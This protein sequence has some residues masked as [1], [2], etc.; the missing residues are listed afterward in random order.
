[1][2]RDESSDGEPSHVTFTGSS[3]R[4]DLVMQKPSSS[5]SLPAGAYHYELTGP[6]YAR[7]GQPD[8]EGTLTCRRWRRYEFTIVTTFGGPSH[9]D[10]G[11]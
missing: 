10:L 6:G 4:Y 8:M 9:Q 5:I 1:M 2:F 7:T 11:D 3:G